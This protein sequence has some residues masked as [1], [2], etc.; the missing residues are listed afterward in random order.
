MEN[1]LRVL[2]YGGSSLSDTDK[3]KAVA[4]YIAKDFNNGH[5]FI[6]VVSAMGDS[7]NKL[8]LQAQQMATQPDSREMD[9]LLTAGERI[10]ISLMAMALIDIG[11]PAIS[12]T[13][14]QA[15]IITTGQHGDANIS[16]VKPYRVVEEIKKNKVVVLA[17]FQGVNSETK[18][19]TTLGRGGS[20]TT[21]IAMASYFKCANCEFMKDTEGIFDKDP[22]VYPEA[23]HIDQLSWSEILQ[24]AKKGEP[25][26][27][28]K[29][30]QMA[31]D[32][33]L[34]LILRHAHR[35]NGKVTTVQ[36]Q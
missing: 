25:F 27:H 33:K 8:L 18:D 31:F 2:K 24:R 16:E 20:D 29:A 22:H 19:V 32:K 34:P 11:I 15:G 35:P 10:S 26:L 9:M 23:K 3:I 21:A 4:K 12:F 5:R 28:E 36:G 30:A 14:S 13:G 6:I 17:G 1:L 7:T